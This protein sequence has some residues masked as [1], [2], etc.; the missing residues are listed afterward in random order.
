M[1][2]K[3]KKAFIEVLVVLAMFG[4]VSLAINLYKARDLARGPA[5]LI[6]GQTIEGKAVNPLTGQPVLV[7]FWA[8]WCPIC[9]LE[10]DSI[11]SVAEDYPVI[12][13]AMQ[14]GDAGELR[15]FMQQQQLSFPV[16]ADEDGTLASQWGVKGVP[17]SFI[18]TAEGN[19]RFV[20]VGYTS[21]AGLRARLWWAALHS[22]SS[23]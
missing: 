7:H 13:V 21:E 3:F 18:L 2:K 8:T 19:I 4:I 22:D 15:Q 12:T 1:N 11:E 6:S 10:Q 5:P 9:S 17:S 20:E 16:T 14:S 23:D